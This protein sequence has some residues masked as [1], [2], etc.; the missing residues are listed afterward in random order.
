VTSLEVP[1]RA[2][3]VARTRRWRWPR[4]AL[5]VVIVLLLGGVVGGAAAR[6]DHAANYQPLIVGTGGGPVTVD[7][8]KI[9]RDPSGVTRWLL[10]AK[11]GATGTLNYEVDND[12]SDP[13]TIDNVSGPTGALIHTSFRWMTSIY[14]GSPVRA[15]PAVVPPHHA[16]TLLISI[17]KPVCP[18]NSGP[19]EIDYLTVHSSAFGF[20]H[21]IVSSLDRTL[22]PID[23][24]WT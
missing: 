11:P 10:A 4:W 2:D 13:V 3:P 24:C 16:I 14:D 1:F 17:R 21:T 8:F 22:G 23:V 6:I 9:A 5:P 19:V 7:A 15:L 12:G 18:A 20:G